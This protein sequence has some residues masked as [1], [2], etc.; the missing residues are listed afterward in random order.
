[1]KV[2]KTLVALEGA[3]VSLMDTIRFKGRLW[4]VPAWIKSSADGWF[5]PL[6]LICLDG[7]PHQKAPKDTGDFVLT[8]PLPRAVFDGLVPAGMELTFVIV[9]RPQI[10]ISIPTKA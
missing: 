7:L 1:M 5:S 6:R 10:R 8:H 2:M 9:E 4:L 3:N